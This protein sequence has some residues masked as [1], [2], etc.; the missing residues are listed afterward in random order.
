[1]AR[2]GYAWWVC[3]VS[4]GILQTVVYGCS[5]QVKCARVSW[6]ICSVVGFC[7]STV[8]DTIC[9]RLGVPRAEC[10]GRVGRFLWLCGKVLGIIYFFPSRCLIGKTRRR[11]KNRKTFIL[12]VFRPPPPLPPLAC[13]EPL[14]HF[15]FLASSESFL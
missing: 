3:T 8:Y 1:M 10:G 15:F 12:S 5:G 13:Q 6:W 14:H 7:P 4:Y 2:Y 9:R 11:N